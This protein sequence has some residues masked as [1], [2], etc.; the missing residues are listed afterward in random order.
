MDIM[1]RLGFG[2]GVVCECVVVVVVWLN[3]VVYG[4]AGGFSF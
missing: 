4:W 3:G 2:R 1:G